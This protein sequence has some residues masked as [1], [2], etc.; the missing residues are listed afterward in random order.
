MTI[1]EAFGLAVRGVRRH[2]RISQTELAALV[3]IA[4]QSVW[5]LEHGRSGPHLSTVYKLADALQVAPDELIRRT[6]IAYRDQVR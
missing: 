6:T 2:R 1:E 5:E 3:G 4:R